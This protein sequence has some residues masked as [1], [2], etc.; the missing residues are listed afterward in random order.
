MFYSPV[1]AILDEV[2]AERRNQDS[3]FGQQDHINGTGGSAYEDL[4]DYQRTEY[5]NA[6]VM[7]W[8]LILLEEVYEALAESNRERLRQEL[9]QVAAV[10]IAWIE[11]IDRRKDK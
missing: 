5:K 3:T 2:S 9:V 7:S 11:A 1:A 6:E 10:C 4:L 8:D